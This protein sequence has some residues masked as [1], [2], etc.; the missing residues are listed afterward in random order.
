MED[1]VARVQ[2]EAE[3]ETCLGI[4]L[5]VF[6][7]EQR[8]PPEEEI[9]G[10]DPEATHL[11]AYHGG[12]PAGTLRLRE[13]KGAAKIERLAV[14]K[15]ARGAGLGRRLMRAVEAE[16]RARGLTL[17]TLGAQLRVIPFYERLGYT[18]EGPVFLD[19]KIPHRRMSKRLT[20]EA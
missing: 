4:R 17:C 5:R 10:L 2:T 8:V 15:A 12:A 18:A 19:A 1:G 16:A 14:D 20:R 11:L 3:L 7:D 9:D 13:V 6:V